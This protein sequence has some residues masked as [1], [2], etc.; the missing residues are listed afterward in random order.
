MGDPKR[1]VIIGGG[2]SGLAC[3]YRLKKLGVPVTLL[4][5]SPR[6]GGLIQSVEENGFLFESGPQ[7]FQGTETLLGLIHDLGIEDELCKADPGAPRWVLRRGKLRKIPMSPQAI[8]TTS[9]LSPGTRWKVASEPFKRTQPPN[10]DESVAAFVRRKFGHEILEYLVSP[11]V[12]GVYAGDPE[13]LSLRAAFPTLEE[14]EREYGSVL[15]GAMKSRS[16]ASS[17]S[18]TARKGPPPLCSFRRGL[19][20]LMQALGA[21]LGEDLRAGACAVGVNRSG[22]AGDAG[23]GIRVANGGHE[24]TLFA[25]AVVFATPAYIASRLVGPVAPQLSSILSGI[26]Y[27]SLAVVGTAYHRKQAGAD[28]DG[29]GVLI[30]RAEKHHTLGIVWNSSLFA[31]RAPEGQM[32]LTSFVGGATDP[33]MIAKTDQEI[34]ALVQEEHAK[35]LG[36]TGSPIQAAVWKHAKALPQYNLGHGYVVQAIRETERTVAGLYF[37]GNYLEGPSIGKCVEDGFETADAIRDYLGAQ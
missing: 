22:S 33:K 7:S 1:T 23:Y 27:A 9:L 19:S 34:M 8:L 35:I 30:P 20:T 32:V 2:I 10:E 21:S 3:A 12:S 15:R 28:L 31:G 16:A 36:I 11:F 37:A 6:V 13:K 17:G 25:Q 5:A 26:A 4:E 14:W 18:S 24:E 29:F